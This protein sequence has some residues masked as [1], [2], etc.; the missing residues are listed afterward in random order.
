MSSRNIVCILVASLLILMISGCGNNTD[1]VKNGKRNKTDKITYG[2]A[3][4]KTFENGTWTELQEKD[5]LGNT[6]VQFTGKIS[7]GFH[8]YAVEKLT[9]SGNRSM[10]VNG[11]HYLAAEIK[12]G[13]TAEDSDITFDTT[14][15]P[16]GK[17]GLVFTDRIEDYLSSKDNNEK[18]T[19]LVDFYKKKY[20]E[21]GTEVTLKF[22]VIYKGKIIKIYDAASKNWEYDM[23]FSG[24]QG[25]DNVIR[26]VFDYA[27][28]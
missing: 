22:S 7:Q 9:K 25:P 26:T 11:C 17:T 21:P 10:F 4:A 1:K 27:I 19:T 6:L 3:F 5:N 18:I 24:T 28:E 23:M 20:F 13:K 16:I 15:F 2:E 12:A 14:M 8:D